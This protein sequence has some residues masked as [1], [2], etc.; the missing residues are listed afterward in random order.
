MPA[1]PMFRRKQYIVKKGMQFRYIGIVFGLVILAS[2]ITGYTVF[3]TGWTLLGEK[4]ASVYPQ[5]RLMF[6]IKATNVAL[7]RNLLFISPALFILPLLF[8]HRIAGPVYRIEKS[9]LDIT[10]GDLA[11]KIKLRKG[12]ELTD[13]AEIINSMTENIRTTIALNKDKSAAIQKDL[14]NIRSAIAAQPQDRAKIESVITSLQTKLTELDSS[15]NTWTT[16]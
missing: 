15:L 16:S 2:I 9:I 7:I 14:D 1:K 5:G 3:A 6:V 12:D 4:L 10:K 13:L 8:S 11:L